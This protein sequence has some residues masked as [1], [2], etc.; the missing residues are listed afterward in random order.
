MS[1]ESIVFLGAAVFAISI[2]A[3]FFGLGDYKKRKYR[4]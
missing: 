1:F 4:K 2:L 3:A